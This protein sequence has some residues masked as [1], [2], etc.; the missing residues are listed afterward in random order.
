MQKNQREIYSNKV[1]GLLKGEKGEGE[2]EIHY[3]VQNWVSRPNINDFRHPTCHK[4]FEKRLEKGGK[5]E[6]ENY[7]SPL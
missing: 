6:G 4:V 2:V 3:I 7:F 5:N 1:S